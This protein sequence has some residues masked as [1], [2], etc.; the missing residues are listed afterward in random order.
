M[1]EATIAAATSC[2]PSRLTS[3]EGSMS[4]HIGGLIRAMQWP[5]GLSGGRETACVERGAKERRPVRTGGMADAQAMLRSRVTATVSEPDRGGLRPPRQF[6]SD[7]PPR[8]SV[9]WARLEP[10]PGVHDQAAIGT[11]ASS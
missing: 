6:G 9:E 2:V 5:E 1:T 8:L 4:A 3:S 10:E 11:T 7:P